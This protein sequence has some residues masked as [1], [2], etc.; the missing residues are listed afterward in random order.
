MK[1]NYNDFL[2]MGLLLIGLAFYFFSSI[3]FTP[4]DALIEKIGNVEEVRLDYNWVKSTK[5]GR[6]VKCELAIFL[7]ED[8]AKYSIFENIGQKTFHPKFEQIKNDLKTNQSVKIWIRKTEES[9]KEPNVFQIVNQGN[10]ILYDIKDAKSLSKFG[11]IL[12][13][14]L[15]LIFII[16]SFRKK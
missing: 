5:G 4:K 9:S 8:N 16:I 1:I 3:L 15:G 14:S 2:F 12:A 13:F 7:K 11:F 10:E 6:S